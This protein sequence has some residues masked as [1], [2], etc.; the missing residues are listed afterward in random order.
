MKRKAMRYL[1]KTVA[2]VLA[3]VFCF[4][5]LETNA[6]KGDAVVNIPENRA[7]GEFEDS[8]VLSTYTTYF[9][10]DNGSC[11]YSYDEAGELYYSKEEMIY[12]ID[13]CKVKKIYEIRPS[14]T[15][16]IAYL[17]TYRYLEDKTL[18]YMD[19]YDHGVYEY[20]R[21]WVWDK[22]G[23]E[24]L[25][26]QY[27]TEG[28]IK[29]VD[30]S[31]YDEEGRLAYEFSDLSGLEERI[32]DASPMRS[33]QYSG[34]Y[35]VYGYTQEWVNGEKKACS[36]KDEMD[37]K[38]LLEAEYADELN[39]MYWY[40]Y[41][42]EGKLLYEIVCMPQWD[43]EYY[44]VELTHYLY[45]DQGRCKESYSYQV[46]GDLVVQDTGLYS[47]EYRC[48]VAIFGDR[49]YPTDIMAESTDTE[50]AVILFDLHTG[51]FWDM[52]MGEN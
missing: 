36:R 49:E 41:D 29:S 11:K 24:Q 3:G 38:V 33:Y 1:A 27:D 5:E 40:S 39:D 43:A 18:G 50:P 26:V 28:N 19:K 2:L 12:E 30:C 14:A 15:E 9:Y 45:D 20:G 22:D 17:Y 23:R 35:T 34:D 13:G 37:G 52:D 48:F 21:G 31:Y 46:V 32:M 7:L 44:E 47:G 42:D 10:T 8:L 16:A 6:A 25:D 51:E 4:G